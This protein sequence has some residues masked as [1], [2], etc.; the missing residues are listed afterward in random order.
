MKEAGYTFGTVQGR[1]VAVQR[2]NSGLELIHFI[3]EIRKYVDYKHYFSILKFRHFLLCDDQ[4]VSDTK[5]LINSFSKNLSDSFREN[6]LKIFQRKTKLCL[7]GV[8][9]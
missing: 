2:Q 6:C 8:S 9:I 1:Q 4:I 5:K 7:H 3:R